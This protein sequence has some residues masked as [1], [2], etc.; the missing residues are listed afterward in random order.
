M[1]DELLTLDDIAARVGESRKYIRDRVVKRGDF[2]RP[3]LS[4]SQKVRKW[5]T[6]DIDKWMLKQKALVAR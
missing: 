1:S 5:A 3:A 6:Q 4:L 2:P